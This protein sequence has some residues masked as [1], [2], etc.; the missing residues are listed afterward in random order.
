M[1]YK[2]QN[3][4]NNVENTVYQSDYNYSL[5]AIHNDKISTKYNIGIYKPL[6]YRFIISL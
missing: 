6:A 1:K 2:K 3:I 4:L 5:H